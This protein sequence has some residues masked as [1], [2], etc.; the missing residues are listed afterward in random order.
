M[1]GSKQGARTTPQS[2]E[3]PGYL[4]QQSPAHPWYRLLLRRR[5]YNLLLPLFQ[6]QLQHL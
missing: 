3:S 5:W 1:L 6:P 4:S 2:H